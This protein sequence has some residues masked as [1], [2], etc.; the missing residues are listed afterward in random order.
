MWD[1][2]SSGMNFYIKL[3]VGAIVVKSDW[4]WL[5]ND[6]YYSHNSQWTNSSIVN[7]TNL[8]SS[9]CPH[10]QNKQLNIISAIFYEL[11]TLIVSLEVF[12]NPR[13]TFLSLACFFHSILCPQFIFLLLQVS[14]KEDKW[15]ESPEQTRSCT[16]WKVSTQNWKANIDID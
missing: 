4:D 14:E 6:Q 13:Q 11:L 12:F 10:H 3:N 15:Q 1:N 7:M 16:S 8:T 5:L 2:L 9:T